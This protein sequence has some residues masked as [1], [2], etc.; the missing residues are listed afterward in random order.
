MPAGGG[1]SPCHGPHVHWGVGVSVV[2]LLRRCNLG[3]GSMVRRGRR[4]RPAFRPVTA[5]SYPVLSCLGGSTCSSPYRLSCCLRGSLRCGPCSLLPCT[6][7]VSV[8]TSPCAGA[9]VALSPCAGLMRGLLWWQGHSGQQL[10]G[11][12]E[13]SPDRS[14]SLACEGEGCETW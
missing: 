2:L 7:E 10:Y 14:S 5:S 4:R 1:R 11:Q 3:W 9:R 13:S 12:S 6:V 8:G